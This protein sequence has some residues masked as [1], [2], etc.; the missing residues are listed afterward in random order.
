MAATQNYIDKVVLNSNSTPVDVY[1]QPLGEDLAPLFDDNPSSTA[2]YA[3]G[4]YCMHNAQLYKC[5]TATTGG[6]W[7]AASWTAVTV[8]DE[9]SNLKN[10]IEQILTQMAY[11]I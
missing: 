8:S 2:T 5:T 1:S 11:M 4:D 10:A 6:T 7:T 3:V 9:I